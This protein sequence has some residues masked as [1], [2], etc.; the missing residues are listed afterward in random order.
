MDKYVKNLPKLAY[1]KLH[2]IG[3]SLFFGSFAVYYYNK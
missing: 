1:G 2:F 3:I